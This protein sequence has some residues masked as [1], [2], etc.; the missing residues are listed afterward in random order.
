ME[1]AEQVQRL[2][3][4]A[5]RCGVVDDELLAGRVAYVEGLV[6]EGEGTDVR[7]VEVFG[8]LGLAAHGVAVPLA[9]ERG[10]VL[11]EGADQLARPRSVQV[12][13]RRVAE[14]GDGGLG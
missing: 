14:V 7:V 12:E 4:G 11:G 10:A 6:G 9:G 2:G 13:T 3:T 8:V 5:A 1:G